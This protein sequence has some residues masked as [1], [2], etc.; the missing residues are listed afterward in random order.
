[1]N[2]YDIGY[3]FGKFYKKRPIIQVGVFLILLCLLLNFKYII[4][5]LL[6]FVILIAIILIIQYGIKN[7]WF[8]TY[9]EKKLKDINRNL[10]E[11]NEILRSLNKKT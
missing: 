7:D 4:S 5:F 11:Q 2:L 9:E 6:P 1:M 10:E 8:L 3:V